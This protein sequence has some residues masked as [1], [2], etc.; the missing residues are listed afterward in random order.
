MYKEDLVVQTHIAFNK[1]ATFDDITKLWLFIFWISLNP[2]ESTRFKFGLQ[3]ISQTNQD[4]NSLVS[5]R[6]SWY[7]ST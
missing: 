1:K 3:N 5:I 2:A 7:T 4:T 6:T